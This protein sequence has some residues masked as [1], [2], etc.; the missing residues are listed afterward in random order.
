MTEFTE[1]EL[2]LLESIITNPTGNVFC[3]TGLSPELAGGALARYSR[4]PT[5]FKETIL[6]EFLDENGNP[7]VE[8]GS[9]LMNRVLNQ[10]GDESVSELA[11]TW[12]C[13][14]DVSNLITKIVEDRRIGGSPIEESTRYVL[15]DKKVDGEW[16]YVRPSSIMQN[17]VGEL[18]V[19]TMDHLFETYT[20]MVEP[21]KGLFKKRL[22]RDK[23][24]IDVFRDGKKVEKV[25][26]NELMNDDEKRAFNNAYNF[27]IRSA[28][29]DVI[30]CILPA[31]T[32]ANVGLYGNGRFYM[33]LLSRLWS[34]PLVE[35]NE[36]ADKIKVELDKVIPT[37]I[38]RA[39]KNHYFENVNREMWRLATTLF[40]NVEIAKEQEVVL[41]EDD[42]EDFLDN[43]V[44]EMLFPWVRHPTRQ[45][46][47]HVKSFSKEMKQNVLAT[48]FGKRDSR[49]DRPGRSL[50]F[51]YPIR[52]DLV[53]GFAEYRD[54]QR[55]RMLTQ[56]RQDLGVDLGYS[57]PEEIT[58]IRMFNQVQEC[59]GKSEHLHSELKR[60]GF[61]V[62]AQYAP[63]FNHFIR[64]SM[65][66]VPR[67]LG[68]LTELRTQPAGHP[69]YRRMTQ[70]MAKIYLAKHPEMEPLLHH[71]NYTDD[72]NKI[73]RAESEARSAYKS[74]VTGVENKEEW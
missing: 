49:R 53:G 74:L 12:L 38:K 36:L 35:A 39:E 5:G 13:L 28:A 55:H 32:K 73:A 33:N 56:Q 11:G 18:Y 20:S 29:C 21:M 68:H 44:A 9:E 31:A 51:G 43:L 34:E 57:V 71:V 2:K 64:W 60:S 25:H 3:I 48:Y 27:T 23:F 59:F 45:I 40:G 37:Y 15:Y 41:F 30:R 26:E 61:I 4:A 54:L 72:G 8:K 70:N 17:S 6:R 69:R 63:L 58:E 65:G 42:K 46:R 10:F 14:E 52:F 22:P 67:E 16:R 1:K 50:E 24:T 47:G 19:E 7:S 66:M 62:E